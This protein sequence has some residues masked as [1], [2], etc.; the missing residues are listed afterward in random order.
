MPWTLYWLIKKQSTIVC[1]ATLRNASSG[2]A[3]LHS[4]LNDSTVC[5]IQR[6]A[7]SPVHSN[8]DGKPH[9]ANLP[10]RKKPTHVKPM[11]CVLSHFQHSCVSNFATFPKRCRHCGAQGKSLQLNK[12]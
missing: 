12:R 11:P 3:T 10:K 5:L 8:S 7:S 6:I 2:H 9:Y 1:F 4:L